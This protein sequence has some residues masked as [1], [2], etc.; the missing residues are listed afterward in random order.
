MPIKVRYILIRLY[1]AK[2]QQ[3]R[4]LRRLHLLSPITSTGA[5]STAVRE[6]SLL[7]YPLVLSLCSHHIIIIIVIF[8]TVVHVYIGDLYTGA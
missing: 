6:L 1:P 2:H 7:S 4:Y 8:N 3:S 5:R